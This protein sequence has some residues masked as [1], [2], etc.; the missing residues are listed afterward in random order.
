MTF[1]INYS[2]M[3]YNRFSSYH[4]IGSW[5]AASQWTGREPLVFGM[6]FFVWLVAGAGGTVVF[7]IGWAWFMCFAL[8][9]GRRLAVD[10][11]PWRAPGFV[12]D[13]NARSGLGAWGCWLSNYNGIH[14]A[15]F[16][17]ATTTNSTALNNTWS[18]P[19]HF[20]NGH[21]TRILIE[22]FLVCTTTNWSRFS[23]TSYR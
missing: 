14:G 16:V 1:S 7:S 2:F 19:P 13:M 23:L 3:C 21:I 9:H 18:I 17:P 5:S 20:V 11:V 22:R 6:M 4:M 10:L 12:N 8:M 15:L